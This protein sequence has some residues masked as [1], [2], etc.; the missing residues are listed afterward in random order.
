MDDGNLE[1]TQ[2][3]Y[4]VQIPDAEMLSTIYSLARHDGLFVGGSSGINVAGAIRLATSLGPGHTVVTV[5]CDSGARYASKLLN[6]T[7]LESRGLPPPPLRDI[8]SRTRSSGFWSTRMTP[9]L[10]GLLEIPCR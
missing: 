1:G 4:A 3:D 10:R 8:H 7:F 6:A 5:L 2:I 9:A